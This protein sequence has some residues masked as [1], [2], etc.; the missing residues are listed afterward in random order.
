MK[1]MCRQ[2]RKEIKSS[3]SEKNTCSSETYSWSL[4]VET[5]YDVLVAVEEVVERL[6]V[7]CEEYLH[8]LAMLGLLG[9]LLLQLSMSFGWLIGGA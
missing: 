9:T 2:I 7:V 5:E 4:S 8:R 6:G 1:T 3:R